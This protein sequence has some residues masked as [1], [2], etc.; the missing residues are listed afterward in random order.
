MN[1]IN[2]YFTRIFQ[3]VFL[4]AKRGKGLGG[5][6]VGNPKNGFLGLFDFWGYLKNKQI[7]SFPEGK[8]RW[9]LLGL[10]IPGS[11]VDQYE[12]LKS[13]PVLGYILADFDKSLV[14]D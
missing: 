5:K 6:D 14:A 8:L 3:V 2:G 9:C 7:D 1:L 11:A 13:G 10:I 12:A 4:G